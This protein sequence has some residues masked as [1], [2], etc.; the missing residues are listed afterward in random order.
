[1]QIKNLQLRA[2]VIV[3]GL[4]AGIH[5][6]PYHGFSVEFSEYRQYT[7]GDD[8]RFLDWRV[9]ARSDRQYVKRFED[10]TNLFSYILTDVSRSMGYGSLDY[11][12]SEYARTLAVALAHFL[13]RQRDATGLVV[14]DE[15]IVDFVPPGRRPGQLNRIA[16][17]L[18]RE[19]RGNSTD[20]RTPLEEI[21]RT[22]RRR[23]LIVLISDLLVDAGEFREQLKYLRSRS[24]DV[25]VFRVLDPAEFDLS[26]SES[27]IFQDLESG[28]RVYIDPESARAQYTRRFQAHAAE[29]ERDC[30]NMGIDFVTCPTDRPIEFMLSDLL[31]TRMQRSRRA[32]RRTESSRREI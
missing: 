6:S 21:A 18:D 23:G 7:S 19:P 16:A 26:C 11:P 28:R 4:H 8:L 27:A 1:M 3:D 2:R 9:L 14:F 24:H 12:K 29:L 17:A 22:V 32:V 30:R 20:V 25:I 15:Q 5:K 31:A 13:H 10:E